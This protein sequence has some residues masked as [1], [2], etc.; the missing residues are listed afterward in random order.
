MS[1]ASSEQNMKTISSNNIHIL[2]YTC[3]RM[4]Q[5]KRMRWAVHVTSIEKTGNIKSKRFLP[6]R[7]LLAI[8][9]I[10]RNRPDFLIKTSKMQIFLIIC[11]EKALHVPGGSYA[12]HQEHIISGIVNL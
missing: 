5:S 3:V 2:M 8:C 7:E 9:C 6:L 1:D 11:F 4:F 10:T 12:Q